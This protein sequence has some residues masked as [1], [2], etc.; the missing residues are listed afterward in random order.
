MTKVIRMVS[1]VSLFFIMFCMCNFLGPCQ[2]VRNTVETILSL[3]DPELEDCMYGD[4]FP[5]VPVMKDEEIT[6]PL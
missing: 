1:I 6:V 5:L 4:L 2:R 3:D